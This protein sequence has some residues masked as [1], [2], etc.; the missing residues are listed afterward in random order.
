MKLRVVKS[1]KKVITLE[2]KYSV[3][4]TL[5][6]ALKESKDIEKVVIIAKTKDG[7]ILTG[8]SDMMASD[9]VVMCELAKQEFIG[10]FTDVNS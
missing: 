6:Q 1:R 7:G 2:Q 10:Q 4:N 3:R 8:W 5:Q 9:G